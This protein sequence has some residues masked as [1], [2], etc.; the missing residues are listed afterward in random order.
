MKQGYKTGIV[1][2]ET[3]QVTIPVNGVYY[4]IIKLYTK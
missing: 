1:H 2:L 3:S 4:A